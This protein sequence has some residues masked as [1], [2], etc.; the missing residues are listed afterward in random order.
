MKRGKADDIE[1]ETEKL[2]V[3]FLAEVPFD[4]ELED[5]IGDVAKLLGTVFAQTIREL[6]ASDITQ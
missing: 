6:A 2:G 5:A 4:P 1:R 3:K